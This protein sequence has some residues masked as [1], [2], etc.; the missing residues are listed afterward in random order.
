ML[1]VTSATR[2]PPAKI[3]EIKRFTPAEWAKAKA[4]DKLIAH[5]A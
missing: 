4:K 5:A 3:T 2:V 1:S